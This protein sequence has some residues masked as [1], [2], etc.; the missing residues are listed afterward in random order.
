MAT[1]DEKYVRYELSAHI[2]GIRV[3]ARSI[4]NEH[5]EKTLAHW[6]KMRAKDIHVVEHEAP[7]LPTWK[8][9]VPTRRYPHHFTM[10][11]SSAA[12]VKSRLEQQKYKPWQ[13]LMAKIEEVA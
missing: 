8:V 11:A 5:K 4:T 2:G 6:R 13:V 3:S 10:Q 7:A 12:V 1:L 9:E